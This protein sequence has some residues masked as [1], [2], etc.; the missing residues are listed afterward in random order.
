MDQLQASF[1]MVACLIDRVRQAITNYFQ[2]RQPSGTLYSNMIILLKVF[3]FLVHL[4]NCNLL[5]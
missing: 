4:E 5:D 1:R 2:S 3:L